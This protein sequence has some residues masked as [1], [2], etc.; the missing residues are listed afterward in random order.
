MKER[1]RVLLITLTACC[2]GG[3]S[4]YIDAE[5]DFILNSNILT[6]LK[7]ELKKKNLK[8]D[9]NH[10]E[11]IP[12]EIKKHEEQIAE[13]IGSLKDYGDLSMKQR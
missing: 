12:G 5:N 10:K 13:F 11:S 7:K 3:Y 1:S 6:K 9:S 8:T 2:Y 4:T